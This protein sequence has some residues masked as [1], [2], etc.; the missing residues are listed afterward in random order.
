MG[1]LFNADAKVTKFNMGTPVD[2]TAGNTGGLGGLFAY[3]HFVGKPLPI[4]ECRPY[5]KSWQ[6]YLLDT[7]GAALAKF[8]AK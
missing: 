8:A 1:V 2:R 4:P 3:L 5:R 6:F 7:V